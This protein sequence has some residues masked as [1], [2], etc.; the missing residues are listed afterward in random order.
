MFFFNVWEI[1]FVSLNFKM[2]K[3]LL[4]VVAIVGIM[5]A[6][7]SQTIQPCPGFR[8]FTQGGWGSTPNGNNPGTILANGFSAVFPNG[9]TI[10]CN[11]KI[12]LTS[13]TAVRNFLPQGSS[14]RVLNAGTLTNP[15]RSTYSNVLAG[16]LVA[17]TLSTEFDAKQASFATSSA[18][19]KDLKVSSGPFFDKTVAEVLTM[20]NNFI[21]GCGSTNTAS[22]FNTILTSLNQSYDNG[23]ATG[24]QFVCPITC[25]VNSTNVSCYGGSNGSIS[26]TNVTSGVGGPFTYAWSNGAT[27]SSVSN[28]SAGT[29]TVIVRDRIGISKSITV[30][31][32][33]PTQL[34]A[35]ATQTS[36]ILCFGGMAD[37]SVSGNG[38]T[39]PYVG[40]GK[41][42]VTAGTYFYTI[43]DANGCT[44]SASI[45]VTEPAQLVVKVTGND[46]LCHGGTTLVDVNA[47]GGTTP[48]SGDGQF[49]VSAGNY[50]YVVTDANGCVDSSSIT[51]NE[52]SP[53]ALKGYTNDDNSCNGGACS[54]SAI[55]LANGG[56][57]PYQYAWSSGISTTDSLGGLCENDIVSVTVTDGNG[58]TDNFG[59]DPIACTVIKSNCDALKTF[60]QGGWAVVPRGGNPGVYM[61]N[62]FSSAFPN[63][64][65]IGS[66][67]NKLSLTSAASVTSFLPSGGT[68]AALSAGNL[69]NPT[70]YGN[71]FAG[72]LV[73]ATLNVT[74]D[75]YDPS[76]TSSNNQ[77]SSYVCTFSPFNGVSV[78]QL[79]MEANRAIGGGSTAYTISDLNDA[80]TKL[81]ENYDNGTVDLGYFTCSLTCDTLT[82]FTQGGYGA[83]PNGNNPGMYV[84]K[85]F[86][87]AF[88]NG[89]VIGSKNTLT[90]NSAQD[91]E[92]FLPSG[93]P[94]RVLASG[95]NINPTTLGNTLAG[96]LV[97]ATLSVTFD[98][99]DAN[100]ATSS[101]SLSSRYCNFAPFYGYSVTQLIAEANQAIGG[102]SAPK[103][104]TDYNMALTKLNEN[105][106]NGNM[107]KGDFS[108][109]P[110][111]APSSR[112]GQF[113][114]KSEISMYPNPS[115]GLLNITFS[116]DKSSFV[117]VNVLNIAGQV[118][119]SSMI[120]ALSGY[121]FHQVDLSSLN[122]GMIVV[123][124]KMEQNVV[125]KQIV[126]TK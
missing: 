40:E 19:L 82:T 117:Q 22:Q 112:I 49:T 54:G 91:V 120:N 87:G 27:T 119:S 70:S 71:T 126:L 56:T 96:Q 57:T 28:L 115:N 121:N 5:T 118:V 84:S 13:A 93:G 85:N 6:S 88:P 81:N 83:A 48:Y 30:Q 45:T 122:S 103:S 9:L 43:T 31:V 92:N 100:F 73:A 74:F 111:N 95:N 66:S 113:S 35:N 60:T 64:L 24:S 26:L 1:I 109:D 58:C 29:Y 67:T 72:Q 50:S 107:D 39:P 53:L 41:F 52:P 97:A 42:N 21:G 25:T 10:G 55:V 125:R 86:A 18:N 114:P 2:K 106:D 32:S 78:S 61:T 34:V 51:I 4:S 123:E 75:S 110:T 8:T 105:Y 94:S 90:L 16:Q 62:N 46:V 12:V 33:Q 47:N 20:A 44:A 89:L 7:T 124:I 38:G 79:L 59:F 14:A 77:L 76:F 99:Y 104:L 15:T 108:C 23:N 36:N 17:A 116:A 37:V 101:Q 102:N 69:I 98:A 68:P 3:F 11:N 80:L 65:T 63:G